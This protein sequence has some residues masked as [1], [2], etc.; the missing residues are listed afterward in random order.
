MSSS[1]GP[2]GELLKRKGDEVELDPE[3]ETLR[4]SSSKVG[5]LVKSKRR[6]SSERYEVARTGSSLSLSEREAR[7]GQHGNAQEASCEREEEM[8]SIGA[9]EAL[10][11]LYDPY[12]PYIL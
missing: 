3:D 8:M 2:A 12:E 11:E 7:R 6:S 10:M 1:E 4:A 5:Q 9:A